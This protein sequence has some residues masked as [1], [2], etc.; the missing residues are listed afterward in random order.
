[1]S[2][3]HPGGQGRK[4]R[5]EREDRE[6]GKEGGAGNTSKGYRSQPER[7]SHSQNWNQLKCKMMTVL[8]LSPNSYK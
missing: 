4:G 5:Q 8:D 6:R 3:E 2:L 7:A 1:M